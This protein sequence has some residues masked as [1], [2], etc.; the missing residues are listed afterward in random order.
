[1]KTVIDTPN[2]TGAALPS[3]KQDWEEL[4]A[5]DPLWAI[6]SDPSK[7]GNRWAIEEF[8]KSGPVE[9]AR[10]MS[11]AAQLRLPARRLKALDFGCGVGRI[12]RALSPL[13]E[14]AT[15][16]DIAESM[17]TKAREISPQC[18]F[19]ELSS[20]DWPKRHFDFIYSSHVL[21]H[22][23]STK[24]AKAFI[25]KFVE[26]LAPNGLLVFHVPYFIRL[27]NRIQPRR[28]A[29]GFLRMLNVPSER[30]LALGLQPIRM[31]SLSEHDVRKAV[32]ESGGNILSAG[33][34]PANPAVRAKVYFC[35][36]EEKI[37]Q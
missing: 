17:L 6:S 24:V 23:P 8:L 30:L 22:Q 13:F 32:R 11:H 20:F 33:E 10:V 18:S 35:T 3:H 4:A 34:S 29:Y 19:V 7:K 26:M 21:Q 16:V 31:L 25:S 37:P 2:S 5:N 28:R 1:M 12:T 14:N 9:V 36:L 27:R 15:G